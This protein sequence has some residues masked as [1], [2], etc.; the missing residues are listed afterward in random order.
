MANRLIRIY[1]GSAGGLLLAAATMVFM[2]DWASAGVVLPVDPVFGISMRPL[3]ETAGGMIL[4]V[5][6]VSNFADK[7]DW[8][9]GLTAWLAAVYWGYR[10][11]MMWNGCQEAGVYASPVADAFGLPAGTVAG[12]SDMLFAGLLLGS[13][14]LFVLPP[15]R[16][17]AR[18][19]TGPRDNETT[20]FPEPKA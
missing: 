3:L 9:L 11:G 14:L 5:A 6:L 19:T 18:K 20:D 15:M 1:I 2:G 16:R 10:A 8:A 12:A 17:T 13:G 7:T 4:L